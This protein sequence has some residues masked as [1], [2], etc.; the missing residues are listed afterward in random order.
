[1]TGPADIPLPIAIVISA[2]LLGG[3]LLTLVG[4]IGLLRLKTFY[5]RVHAPTLG[6]SMGMMFILASSIIYFSVSRGA[7]VF[8]EILIVVFLTLTTPISLMLIVRAALARD[9]AEGSADVPH[10]DAD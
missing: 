4:A 9:R 8:H 10:V 1:M 6:S 7:P 3:A 2:C 5:Q